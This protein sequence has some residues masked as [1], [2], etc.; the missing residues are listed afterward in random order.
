M[1]FRP[2]VVFVLGPPGCGKGTQCELIT[3]NFGFKHLSAGDCLRAERYDCCVILF[4][5]WIDPPSPVPIAGWQGH[6][7]AVGAGD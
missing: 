5:V 1:P 4:C 3:K 6:G 7:V 2:D